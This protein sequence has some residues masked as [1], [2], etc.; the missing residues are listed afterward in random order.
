MDKHKLTNIVAFIALM[1][2]GNGLMD[3]SPDYIM[4]KFERYCSPNT[5]PHEF[6]WGLDKDRQEAILK[7]LAQWKVT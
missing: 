4:E 5:D 7:Y 1:Q 3:K 6:M 2:N